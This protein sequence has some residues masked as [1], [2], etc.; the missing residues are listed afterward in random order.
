VFRVRDHDGFH[1]E[2]AVAQIDDGVA[3][4]EVEVWR[5]AAEGLVISE[6]FACTSRS[7][8]WHDDGVA[9]HLEEFFGFE[10][11]CVELDGGEQVELLGALEVFE[12]HP[13]GRDEV[14]EV[15]EDVDEDVE[16]FDLHLVDGHETAVRW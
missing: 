1:V 8:L 13:E 7:L 6:Y 5:R 4:V 9:L 3:G 2:A 15:D 16:R 14:V 12:V 11:G 10:D